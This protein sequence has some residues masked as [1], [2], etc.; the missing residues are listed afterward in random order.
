[1]GY[2]QPKKQLDLKEFLSTPAKRRP[3]GKKFGYRTLTTAPATS[4]EDAPTGE[5][6]SEEPSGS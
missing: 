5:S 3:G 4:Q 6:G 2:S 1:M